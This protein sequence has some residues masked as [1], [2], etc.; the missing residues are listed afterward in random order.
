MKI[1]KYIKYGKNKYKVYLE[2][3]DY[4]VLYEDIILKYDLLL[5]REI[6]DLEL[7]VRENDKYEL[8]DKVLGFISKR[9]RCES[10]IRSYLKKYTNDLEYIDN[11]INK[12]YENKLLDNN[13]YIKSFIHD[14]IEFTNDGP[15]K[16][17]KNLIDLEFDNY[18][19]EDLLVEFNYNLQIE[20]ITNYINKNLKSNSKSLYAFKG[21]M[22][23][24]LI[25][26]GYYKEDIII[27][28]DKI[29]LNEDNLM[30]KEKEKLIKKYSKKF[31]GV[32]LDR[33]I[34]RKLYEK[35]FRN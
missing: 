16:I 26:L 2:N 24:N 23:L 17:K 22:L 21:K 14:K 8:Y 13:L 1:E 33:I 18:L 30:E 25:N 34:K 29:S 19:I 5:K 6:D 28:L 15:L 20:K 3:N 10:E 32:E 4:L 27:C 35:G 7:I 12:L 11:I 31:D 9:I